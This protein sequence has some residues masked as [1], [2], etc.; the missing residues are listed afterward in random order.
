MHRGWTYHIVL[1]GNLEVTVVAVR[2]VPGIVARG[3]RQ[4]GREGRAEEVQ[5]PG[6]DDVVEEVRVEGDQ[7]HRVA[8]TWWQAQ[9]LG[10]R[11]N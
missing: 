10:Q 2:G 4:P 8:D 11:H 7:H 1:C 6:D 3:P 5:R 9:K